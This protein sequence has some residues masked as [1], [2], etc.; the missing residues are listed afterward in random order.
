MDHYNWLRAHRFNDGMS[1][2]VA[3]EGPDAV[4]GIGQ[5]Q[6]FSFD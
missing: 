3:E 2:A 5:P 1:P 4:S 6:Q